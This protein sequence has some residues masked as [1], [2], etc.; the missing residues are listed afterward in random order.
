MIH[1]ET[2]MKELE[3]FVFR[4]VVICHGEMVAIKCAEALFECLWL[5]FRKQYMYVPSTYNQ[6]SLLQ[7]RNKSIWK[8]FNGKNHAELSI[9]YRLSLQQIYNLTRMMRKNPSGCGNRSGRPCAESRNKPLVLVVIEEYLPPA[10][11]KCGL[12]E[13][14]SKNL[15]AEVADFLCRS[16]PGIL[17]KVSDALKNSRKSANLLAA[18]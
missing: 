14:E 7:D 16:F 1:D 15:A 6:A 12:V 10:L 11:I 4:E 13:G 3:N 8:D 2:V 18:N 9:K 5:N 17:I